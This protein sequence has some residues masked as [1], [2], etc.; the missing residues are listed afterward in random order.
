MNGPGLGDTLSPQ[1]ENRSG[2]MNGHMEEQGILV[3]IVERLENP[4]FTVGQELWLGSALIPSQLFTQFFSL[5]LS[6]S[7]LCVLFLVCLFLSHSF[8]AFWF[9]RKNSSQWWMV[10]SIWKDHS[11]IKLLLSIKK[12]KRSPGPSHL[13]PSL[14]PIYLSLCFTSS[15]PHSSLSQ[16]TTFWFSFDHLC[17][18]YNVE[19]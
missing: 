16:S 10:C 5:A 15:S 12:M 6:F 11:F 3:S 17:C 18:T 4:K 2:Y 9:S 19:V 14:S 1:S 13:E 8:L 7:Q